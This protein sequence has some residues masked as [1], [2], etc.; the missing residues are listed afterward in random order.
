M[1]MTCLLCSHEFCWLCRE[2]WSTHGEQTGGY[3]ACNRYATSD[4]KLEDDDNEN[5][6]A[7]LRR[8]LH[9]YERYAQHHRSKEIAA[10]NLDEAPARLQEYM[11]RPSCRVF[12]F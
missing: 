7:Q 11:V 5:R 10:K 2:P 4:A 6:K 1:H 8:F 12:F 9:Y 3:F